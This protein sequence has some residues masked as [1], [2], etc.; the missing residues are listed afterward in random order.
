MYALVGAD[1]IVV[2]IGDDSPCDRP[3]SDGAA[4]SPAGTAALALRL[5]ADE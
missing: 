2:V 5:G 1:A 4:P 3:G